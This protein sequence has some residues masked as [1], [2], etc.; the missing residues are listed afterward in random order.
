MSPFAQ[1]GRASRR[2]SRQRAIHGRDKV[3]AA[4]FQLETPVFE[5]VV[6]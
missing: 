3:I 2:F 4:V 1:Y 6:L 5:P